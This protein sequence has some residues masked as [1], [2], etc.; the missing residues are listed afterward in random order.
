MGVNLDFYKENLHHGKLEKNVIF[1]CLV[2][3]ISLKA[4]IW[5]LS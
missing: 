3:Y 4:H 5:I 2:L 1:N